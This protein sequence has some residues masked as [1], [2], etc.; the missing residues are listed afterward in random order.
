MFYSLDIIKKMQISTICP[1][2]NARRL[3]ASAHC[4]HAGRHGKLLTG[5]ER[6]AIPLVHLSNTSF[7]TTNQRTVIEPRHIPNLTPTWAILHDEHFLILLIGVENSQRTVKRSRDGARTVRCDALDPVQMQ[8]VVM[9]LWSDERLDVF[10]CDNGS[11]RGLLGTPELQARAQ[12][13]AIDEK[14]KWNFL[15]QVEQMVDNLRQ[16]CPMFGR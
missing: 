14:I 13:L 3:I 9:L 4:A 1:Q 6:A 16:S 15:L 2:H 10:N 7:S 5:R 11:L 8:R 12:K